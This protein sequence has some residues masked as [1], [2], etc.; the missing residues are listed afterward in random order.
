MAAIWICGVVNNHGAKLLGFALAAYFVDD[1]ECYALQRREATGRLDE[2]I[3]T[4]FPRNGLLWH[5][6]VRLHHLN[7]CARCDCATAKIG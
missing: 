1:I 3:G 2:Q 7:G 4:E 6:Q 5:I